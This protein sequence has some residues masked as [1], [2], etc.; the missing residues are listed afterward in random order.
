MRDYHD[1]L[2][3]ELLMAEVFGATLEGYFESF[4]GGDHPSKEDGWSPLCRFGG[5]CHGSIQF[6]VKPGCESM[7]EKAKQFVKENFYI[8]EYGEGVKGSPRVQYHVPNSAREIK[9]KYVF[10]PGYGE[11]VTYEGHEH[12]EM[13]HYNGQTR[14]EGQKKTDE[15]FRVYETELIVRARE[16]LSRREREALAKAHGP[17]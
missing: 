8:L 4:P 3:F 5:N 15:F 2:S 17:K 1:F 11:I 6:R 9:A 7:L 16:V 10:L 12:P 13:H 14:E